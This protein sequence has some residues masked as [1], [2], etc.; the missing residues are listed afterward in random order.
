MIASEHLADLRKSGLADSTIEKA[1]IYSV[2]PAD[3]AEKL[4]YDSPKIESLL[5]F[6]YGDNGFERFKPFPSF[7]DKK[8]YKRKYLQRE[9]TG[10]HL[11]IPQSVIPQLQD[12]TVPLYITEGEKKALKAVQEG[13][14]CIAISGLWNWSN[15]TKEL[16]GDFDKIALQN[17]NIY[18]VPDNDWL[19][20]NR[21][22]YKRNLE[23]AV[24]QFSE[25]LK[26]RGAR[27][28]ITKLPQGSA[29]GLD[30]YLCSH[31]VAEFK[32]LPATEYIGCEAPL[33]TFNTFST[34]PV[35][36]PEALYGLAGD[37]VRTIEPE[38]E[39]DNVALLNNLLV[40]FGSVVGDKP[41]FIADGSRHS[42]RLFAVHVGDTSKGR[43][44]TAW[45]HILRLL[46]SVKPEWSFERITRGLSSGEGLI[47]EVRDP[48]EQVKAVKQKGKP[49]EYETIITDS[50][51]LDKRLLV[52]ESEFSSVLKVSGRDGSTL[53]PIIRQAW[54]TG[55]LRTLTKNS[56][57]KATNA[58][59][60]ILGHITKEELLRYLDSTEAGNG[61][62]NRFLWLCVRRS[63]C[64]PEGGRPINLNPLIERLHKS[65][66]FTKSVEEMKRDNGAR[67]IWHAVYPTLSEGKPGLFG[68]LTSRAEA[69]VMRL[70]CIYALL[71][72]SPVIRTEHLLASLALWDYVEASVK[73]IFGNTTGDP[74]ADKILK[75]VESSENGL[76]REDIYKGVFSAHIKSERISNAIKLLISCGLVS[77]ESVESTGGR[78]REVLTLI[79]AQKAY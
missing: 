7:V 14:C 65:I 9:G 35:L 23:Q 66:E 45:A 19:L 58:H 67:E 75:A 6:P 78:P 2:R 68:A 50:G 77:V 73:Y 51:V 49:T 3:I 30:D 21:H 38:T 33:S 44:G 59:I 72:C 71:D 22:G 29:K 61:F 34:Y 76:S 47:W 28:F 26:A 32:T 54:D 36:K 1:G 25:K 5:A 42:M 56:P 53:S 74:V 69:Q 10:N 79:G 20:P 60:S 46:E 57:A 18:L 27:V 17:R 24:Y 11:Y 63:K 43:K 15:G 13:L 52:L 4:G 48:I 31:S 8:G 12:T 41:H 16:I 64:L 62:G 40:A 55:N 39:A 70:A 37:I